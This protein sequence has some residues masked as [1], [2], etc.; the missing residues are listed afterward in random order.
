MSYVNHYLDNICYLQ[1]NYRLD[2]AAIV[3]WD[4]LKCKGRF[5]ISSHMHISR[6]DSVSF[7]SLPENAETSLYFIPISL[8]T[9]G[10]VAAVY[11]HD[12]R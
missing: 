11:I 1:D 7:L 3:M 12:I 2:I 10:L 4:I 5:N 8:A 9:Q 6:P